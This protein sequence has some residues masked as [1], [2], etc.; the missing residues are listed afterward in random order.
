MALQFAQPHTSVPAEPRWVNVAE[1]AAIIR[2][3]LKAR[4]P[5]TRFSVRSSR[6]SMGSS[7]Y[8]SWTD[9]PVTDLVDRALACFRGISFDGSDDSTHYRPIT[10]NGETCKA[11]SYVSSH[12]ALSPAATATVRRLADERGEEFW[13]MASRIAFTGS[14]FLFVKAVR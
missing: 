13:P 1:L 4:F 6:Y 5:K 3:A 10:I 2:K 11:G 8:V 7:V 12:R 14:G 9:G